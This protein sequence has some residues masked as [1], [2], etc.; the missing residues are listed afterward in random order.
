[1][2]PH[3][4]KLPAL[5]PYHAAPLQPAPPPPRH[6]AEVELSAYARLL[7][8]SRWHILG[9]TLACLLA[10]LLYLA[11]AQPVYE[12]SLLVHVEEDKPNNAKSMIGE[13]SS[14]FE[15]K[16][17]AISEMELIKSRMVIGK[18]VDRLGLYI[19]AR[20]EYL[21]LVG[22]LIAAQRSGLSEPGLFGHGGYVWGAEKISVDELYAPE[23]LQDAEFVLTVLDG[24]QFLLTQRAYGLAMRGQVGPRQ[25]FSLPQG[26]LTVRVAAIEARPGARFRLR[27]LPKLA[28]IERVQKAMTVAEIGKQS[29][30]IG[31]TLEGG[32]P[33]QVFLVLSEIGRE[34][35]HQ[36]V[37][38]KLEEAEKSLNFLDKQL[39][40]IQQR[41][42]R[43]EAEYYRYRNS[44]GTIDLGEEAKISL[45]QAAAARAKRLE[46][47]Q[48]RQDMLVGFTASHPLVQALEQQLAATNAEIARA[49][50]HV[51]GLP[52]ME[53]ELL[54]L[55][56]EMKLN[57]DLYGTLLNSAQQ[58]R[59]VKA[60]KVSNVRLVDQPMLPKNPARPERG[61]VI[62]LALAAGLAIGL[63]YACLRRLLHQGI[64]T[65][66]QLERLLGQRVVYASVP[67]SMAEQEL[68][69][70]GVARLLACAAPADPAI[71][72]L[73]GLRTALHSVQ[74]HL[75]NSI[76]QI[77]APHAGL[78]QSFITANLAALLAL[79]GKRVLLVDADLRAGQL[80]RRFG[81]E[82]AG[83]LTEVLAGRLPPARLIVPAGPERLDLLC[84]GALPPNPAEFL[85]HPGFAE[86]LQNMAREYD[87]VLVDTPPLLAVSDPL[88]SAALAGAVFLLAGAGVTTEADIN[89]ALKRLQQGGA[90]TQGIVFND[91][92]R[93]PA[94]V[95][96]RPR[97][98][99]LGRSA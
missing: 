26:R 51:R 58:L 98:R 42:E 17:A 60:G 62:G 4:P 45:Q 12:A 99:L 54:R 38:R 18:S 25:V 13:I 15:V 76:V 75:R 59:L 28:A 22:R 83:G 84:T 1:M 37:T 46:L 94:A 14:L 47:Q 82:R 36:N 6:E 69:R 85:L 29:G 78:G 34:Y 8:E 3:D 97:W 30:L 56:R 67:H 96:A 23:P 39:P 43:S 70:H 91:S 2:R 80:H 57:S 32:D 21:P 71:E 16:A 41:L 44:R 86:L 63:G 27:Y 35:V 52:L 19:D 64:D 95:A 74:P 89:E 92:R 90:A 7:A 79:S 20:P 10:G 49:D 55:N 24:G 40:D 77:S 88:A 50:S 68:D 5:A 48:K 61:K 9:I 11:L 65:P 87:W 72:N 73:R 66:A 31:V 33:Q 81:R 53:R 93:R